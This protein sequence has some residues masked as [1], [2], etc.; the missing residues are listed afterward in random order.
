MYKNGIKH[1]NIKSSN[2]F[3]DNNNLKL[4]DFGLK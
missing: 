1:N 2:L 3:I 4:G